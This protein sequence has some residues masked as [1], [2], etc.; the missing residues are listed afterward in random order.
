[1][2]TVFSLWC[3][4]TAVFWPS[5]LHLVMIVTIHKP[6]LQQGA[7]HN[8]LF[9]IL[10]S[11][12]G[13]YHLYIAPPIPL[14]MDDWQFR[15]EARENEDS[16]YHIGVIWARIEWGRGQRKHRATAEEAQHAPARLSG[17]SITGRNKRLAQSLALNC[18]FVHQLTCLRALLCKSKFV[19]QD[20]KLFRWVAER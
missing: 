6:Y 20:W 8:Y 12:G 13:F 16:S 10:Y 3:K 9:L 11:T 18:T 14:H 17:Q 4:L 7:S 15:G 2:Q 19:K 5:T 1:M